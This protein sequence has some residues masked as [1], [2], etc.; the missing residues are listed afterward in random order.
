MKKT[1]K[2]LRVKSKRHFQ[3]HDSTLKV[4]REFA[5]ESKIQN[6]INQYKKT[7]QIGI[8]N[9]SQP[10]YG[11]ATG[12]DFRESMEIV[13]KAKENFAK[14]PSEIRA[15][16]GNSPEL[17]LNFASDPLN[18]PQM[19]EWGLIDEPDTDVSTLTNEEIREVAEASQSTLKPKE[20]EKPSE[21]GDTAATVPT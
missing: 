11:F 20:R 17:F 12:L 15:K 3:K 1:Q 19:A 9:R 7:G 6:I 4:K 5:A 8:T 10:Q 14:I 21:S 18:Q 16:F 2:T 13:I